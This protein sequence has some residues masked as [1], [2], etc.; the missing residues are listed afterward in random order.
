MGETFN[1]PGTYRIEVSGWGLDGNFFAEKADLTWTHDGEKKVQLRRALPE[2]AI[3]FIRLLSPESPDRTVP[4]AY[5][6]QQVDPMDCNGLCEI[7]LTQLYPR[8]REPLPERRASK[9]MEDAPGVCDVREQ[10]AEL[11]HEEVLR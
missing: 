6:I 9:Q 11:Q 4:I 2:G 8:V 3:V 10:T 5:A 1:S 7:K